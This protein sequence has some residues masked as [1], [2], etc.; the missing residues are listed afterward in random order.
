L[1]PIGNTDPTEL[2]NAENNRVPFRLTNPSLGHWTIAFKSWPS[3]VKTWP[4]WYKRVSASK[5]THWE[6][7]GIS[8]ALALTAVDMAKD[9][10]MMS[11]ATYFW[12]TTLNAFLFNQ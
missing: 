10:P 9:E 1:G 6:E 4:D 7:I 8:Q 3:A 2:I 11:A 12:S 5:Q